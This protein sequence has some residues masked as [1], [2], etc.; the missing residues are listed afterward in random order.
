MLMVKSNVTLID[1]RKN[2]YLMFVTVLDAV[3]ILYPNFLF[4]FSFNFLFSEC[5]FINIQFFFMHF[6]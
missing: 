4:F 5:F 6:F 2:D 1:W 3:D